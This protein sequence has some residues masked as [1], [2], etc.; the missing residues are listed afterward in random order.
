MN[1]YFNRNN[2]Q[3]TKSLN[4]IF[5][6]KS[7]ALDL[8]NNIVDSNSQ[9]LCV[10]RPRRFG[11]SMMAS[12][13][14]AYYSK[15]CDSKALFDN[16]NISKASSYPKHLNK[17]NVIW[18]DMQYELDRYHGNISNFINVLSLGIIKELELSF[19]TDRKSVV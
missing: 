13:I 10:T 12:M 7:D 19:N 8:I 5:V 18:L 11:K 4:G 14:N 2:D 15:G 17:R 9:F 6:D 16:L 3:F 1:K